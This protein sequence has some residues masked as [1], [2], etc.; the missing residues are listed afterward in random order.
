MP[1]PVPTSATAAQSGAPLL[2]NPG[3]QSNNLFTAALNGVNGL[4][5]SRVSLNANERTNVAGALT[6][7]MVTT[8]G[9]SASSQDPS[10]L[11][12]AASQNGDRVFAIA[13]ADPRAQNAAYTSVEVASARTQPIEVS[14]AQALPPPAPVVTVQPVAAVPVVENST[15]SRSLN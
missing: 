13:S 14:S 12:I 10:K 7:N 9:F 6:A 15:P 2:N 4:D 3:N 5:P 1:T 8:P 11:S